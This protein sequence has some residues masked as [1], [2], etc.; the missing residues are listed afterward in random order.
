MNTQ[1]IRK[2][3]ADAA[4][5]DGV[6]EAEHGV[7][8]RQIAEGAAHRCPQCPGCNAPYHICPACAKPVYH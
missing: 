7:S 3:L 5:F 1:K 2:A 6:A 8:K 4:A